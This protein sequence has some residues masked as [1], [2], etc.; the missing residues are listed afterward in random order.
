MFRHSNREM[1][2]FITSFNPIYHTTGALRIKALLS[3]AQYA[4]LSMLC[5]SIKWFRLNTVPGHTIKII[6]A[7]QTIIYILLK[8]NLSLTK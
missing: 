5:Y 8:L 7:Q 6:V 1:H 3:A 2:L 4:A